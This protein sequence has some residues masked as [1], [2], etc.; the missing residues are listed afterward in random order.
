M[1]TQQL[2]EQLMMTAVQSENQEAAAEADQRHLRHLHV[3]EDLVDSVADTCL[4]SVMN[5]KNVN[6]V[7]PAAT[8]RPAIS[9]LESA[10]AAS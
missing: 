4:R 1:T 5:L 9:R 3:N 6:P 2:R 10:G 8:S 7:A